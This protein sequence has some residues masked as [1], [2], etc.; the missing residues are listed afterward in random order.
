MKVV[1]SG[2]AVPKHRESSTELA[3]RLN[4]E[5]GW[6][7]ERTGVL[8]RFVADSAD[9]LEKLAADASAEALRNSP[10]PDL[11]INASVCSRQ[12]IPDNSP[13][14]L[15]ELG[16][17]GIPAFS[18]HANCASFLVAMQITH[19]LI[20]QGTYRRVLVCSAELPTRARNFSDPESAALLGDGAA[21][22]VFE[23]SL[24]TGR[25]TDFLMK[26][27][28]S[29]LAFAQVR[30][31]GFGK[32]PLSELTVPKDY[33]FEMDGP[34]IYRATFPKAAKFFKQFFSQASISPAEIDLVVPHQPSGP[35]LKAITRLGIPEHKIM[36][37]IA[38][39]G[40][41]VAASL[42][43]TLA[44]AIEQDRLKSGD[45]VLFLASGAGLSI[46]ALLMTWH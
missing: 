1:G 14:I 36:T 26:T 28:P 29:A 10:P 33:L 23:K 30:G 11:L 38:D 20:S 5:P 42:P 44:V 18:V 9:T 2:I 45:L 7:V 37:T 25:P 41:C 17:E 6:I 34:G 31:G 21:A 43:I 22:I 19:A 40:N 16:Y 46:A 32:H 24:P 35:G 15:R 12:P 8:S 3:Q 4:V 39:Y 13:F 27:W